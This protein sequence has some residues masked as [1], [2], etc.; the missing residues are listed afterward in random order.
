M[1][2]TWL[3]VKREKNDPQHF[4]VDTRWELKIESQTQKLQGLLH[5]TPVSGAVTIIDPCYGLFL[6]FTFIGKDLRLQKK[7]KN[8]GPSYLP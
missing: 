1:Q 4:L 8:R 3:G 5:E 7:T 2:D 6:Y